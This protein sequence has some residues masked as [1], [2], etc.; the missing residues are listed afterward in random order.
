M[1]SSD[2]ENQRIEPD[3]ALRIHVYDGELYLGK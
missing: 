3:H 1:F 2:E